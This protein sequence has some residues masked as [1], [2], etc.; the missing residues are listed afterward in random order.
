MASS[1]VVN[2]A[3]DRCVAVPERMNGDELRTRIDWQVA[4]PQQ[5][6][7]AVRVTRTAHPS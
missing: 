6:L 4:K 7:P 2:L 3:L 5:Y 1:V